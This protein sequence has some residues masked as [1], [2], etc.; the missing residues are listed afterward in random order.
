[1][2]RVGKSLA[3]NFSLPDVAMTSRKSLLLS[4]R[5]LAA[6]ILGFVY[7]QLYFIGKESWMKIYVINNYII[8]SIC[9]ISIN[10]YTQKLDQFF[11][12]NM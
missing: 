8:T 4:P 3:G 12:K 7:Y 2:I 11:F 10:I 6:I 1:M 9:H 5:S